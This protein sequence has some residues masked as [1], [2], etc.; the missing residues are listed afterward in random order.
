MSIGGGNL[1]GNNILQL[2]SKAQDSS[3]N[4][5]TT[6]STTTSIF[7]IDS[8]SGARSD[9]NF[10]LSSSVFD[11]GAGVILSKSS[12][13]LS[14]PS[15]LASGA[16]LGYFAY[17]GYANNNWY[18]ISYLKGIYRGNGSTRYGDLAFYLA[19]NGDPTE[20]MR[21]CAN[22]NA[23]FCGTV[24]APSMQ[25]TNL[26]AKTT[27]SCV[28][29]INPTGNLSFGT[30]TGNTVITALQLLD[31]S[32]G[33]DVNTIAATPITWTTE[34]FS[35]ASLSFT[36]GS[37]I[38]IQTTGTYEISYVLN[39]NNISGSAKN[40][41]TVIRKNNNADITPLSSSSFSQDVV[42]ES[43]TNVMPQYMVSLSAGDYLELL[44]FRIGA[45]GV[46]NTNANSSW[47][48]IKKL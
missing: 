2:N 43:S 21:I 45:S 40:I 35:G 16:T 4:L 28:I 20:K 34:V 31:I 19:D 10:R 6:I 42:N 47:L 1:T 18:D 5:N 14:S 26:P 13:S 44:A 23:N 12:G 7:E 46:A 39:V 36:G 30:I 38:Y 48:R 41:G 37:R 22:G 3:T 24:C 17:R 9:F 32:G 27:E 8:D 29:Y 11:S 15:N 25:L 33:T